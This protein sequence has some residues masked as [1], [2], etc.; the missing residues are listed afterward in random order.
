MVLVLTIH[1]VQISREEGERLYRLDEA[2]RDQLMTI[3]QQWK[4]K[5]MWFLDV[6]MYV[7]PCLPG[8]L[9]FGQDHCAT[10]ETQIEMLHHQI[11]LYDL[12]ESE[13]GD[14]D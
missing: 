9:F 8:P 10:L 7:W 13:G 3:S 1:M 11:Q 14:V 5:Q 12:S 2:N 4:V 6:C